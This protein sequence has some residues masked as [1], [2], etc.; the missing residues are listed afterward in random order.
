MMGPFKKY[1][2]T[3]C[4]MGVLLICSGMVV[5]SRDQYLA[6]A[7][8]TPLRFQLEVLRLDPAKALPPLSMGDQ[9]TATNTNNATKVINAETTSLTPPAE[10]LPSGTQTTLSPNN[11]SAPVDES[12]N[13][14]SNWEPLPEQ[15]N[16]GSGIASPQML[17]RYFRGGTNEVVVPYSVDFTP[18][19]RDHRTDSSA[20]YISE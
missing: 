13:A 11:P 18:P 5:H 17:L 12:N 3:R 10:H 15:A 16:T 1:K 4:L 2:L 8:P 19:V 20:E 7:G 14:I 6:A 9:V